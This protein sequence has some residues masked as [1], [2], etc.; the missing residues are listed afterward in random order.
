MKRLFF[1]LAAALLLA[2]VPARG[3]SEVSTVGVPAPEA[4]A[5]GTEDLLP[6]IAKAFDGNSVA[7]S[8]ECRTGD[9][10]LGDGTALL[11]ASAYKF[12]TAITEFWCDGTSR[13]MVDRVAEEVV[14]EPVEGDLASVLSS[15]RESY[16]FDAT[17]EGRRATAV[18]AE[19]EQ[20][21]RIQEM[22]A[23]VVEAQAEIPMAIAA[24]LRE[25]KIGVMDY[26][27]MQN[28]MADT[29]MRESL[30]A[31]DSAPAAH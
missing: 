14:I 29:S 19:Q 22:Q 16:P 5:T 12:I 31:A 7:L 27:R 11:T 24:A 25:G 20:R 28:I 17:F 26:L 4:P 15:L 13:W 3:A 23:K 2:G 1:Y 6:A 9:S 30:S 21:A 8:F 18:A 10:S